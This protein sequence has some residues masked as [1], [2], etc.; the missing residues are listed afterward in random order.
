VAALRAEKEEAAA[1]WAVEVAE[2]EAAEQEAAAVRLQSA[3]RGRAARARVE[4]IRT[5]HRE[6]A[7]Q[8]RAVQVDPMKP[9]LTVP[10]TWRLKLNYD[11]RFSSLL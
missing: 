5:E 1:A 9:T 6:D 10:G 8:G 4:A 7:A 2:E 11:E 3:A